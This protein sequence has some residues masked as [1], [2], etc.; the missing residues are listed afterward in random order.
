[1]MAAAALRRVATVAFW[2]RRRRRCRDWYTEPL[3]L[4]S[5]P[6][7]A[8]TS[9]FGGEPGTVRHSRWR[10]C[11]P[12]TSRMVPKPVALCWMLT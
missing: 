11:Q 6:S 7:G 5:V 12:V 10:Y 2:G 9:W 3:G 8:R 1:M 4:G